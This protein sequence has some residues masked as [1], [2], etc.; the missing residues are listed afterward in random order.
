VFLP[1]TDVGFLACKTAADTLK[2]APAMNA[3][4]MITMTMRE[5]ARL[6]ARTGTTWNETYE[7]SGM[8]AKERLKRKY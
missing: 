2:G 4:G 7:S 6:G 3:T 1:N 8:P 5:V